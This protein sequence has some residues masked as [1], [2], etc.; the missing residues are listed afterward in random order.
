MVD[1]RT[2][3]EFE[4]K[5]K[6][7]CFVDGGLVVNF[8]LEFLPGNGVKT[9][10]GGYNL[11]VKYGEGFV[12]DWQSIDYQLKDYLSRYYIN[13]VWVVGEV[14]GYDA[15]KNRI[16]G[17]VIGLLNRLNFNGVF[18]GG[19]EVRERLFVGEYGNVN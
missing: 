14:G 11:L 7:V 12:I 4:C 2:G 18:C 17:C 3:A 19:Y 8:W 9:G 10:Y 5:I 16:V 6:Q 15:V 13:E 1:V